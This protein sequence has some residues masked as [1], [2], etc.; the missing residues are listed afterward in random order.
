MCDVVAPARGRLLDESL[1]SM[2]CMLKCPRARDP[3]PDAVFLKMNDTSTAYQPRLELK[4]LTGLNVITASNH[5][6]LFVLFKPCVVFQLLW[7][8]RPEHYPSN[9][10]TAPKHFP[11]TYSDRSRCDQF[12]RSLFPPT[13]FCFMPTNMQHSICVSGIRQL[14]ISG[15]GFHKHQMEAIKLRTHKRWN[16]VTVFGF[17]EHVLHGKAME[18]G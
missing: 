10:Q 11:F 14:Q 15:E 6:K 8:E 13:L 1:T 2:R 4:K 9:Q 16:I 17:R 3:S 7:P 5:K 18:H 12:T